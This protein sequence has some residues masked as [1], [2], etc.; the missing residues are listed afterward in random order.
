[1][2]GDAPPQIDRLLYGLGMFAPHAPFESFGAAERTSLMSF[3]KAIPFSS[4]TRHLPAISELADTLRRQFRLQLNLIYVLLRHC[5]TFADLE[6]LF[7]DERLETVW[8]ASVPP[9]T[10]SSVQKL[11]SA[12]VEVNRLFPGQRPYDQLNSFVRRVVDIHNSLILPNGEGFGRA[13]VP[14]VAF[15][16]IRGNL[17]IPYARLENTVLPV[18]AREWSEAAEVSST[19]FIK[20]ITALANS[21]VA[22]LDIALEP[23]VFAD[24]PVLGL[25]FRKVAFDPDGDFLGFREAEY[26]ASLRNFWTLKANPPGRFICRARLSVDRLPDRLSSRRAI[27]LEAWQALLLLFDERETDEGKI[28]E[29]LAALLGEPARAVGRQL[30]CVTAFT[31][32][33][34]SVH[35]LGDLARDLHDFLTWLRARILAHTGRVS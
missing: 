21:N 33:E 18:I 28:I 30:H 11:K 31:D 29:S 16:D 6:K 15:P 22:G 13:S 19:V 26:L 9:M 14:S 34:D 17:V 35:A 32:D 7:P 3:L 25:S 10:A 8:T 2:G 27:P 12:F 4:L 1:M 5:P 23:V 24:D 20:A